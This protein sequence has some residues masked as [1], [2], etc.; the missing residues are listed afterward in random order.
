MAAGAYN[1]LW[2]SFVPPAC[3][4]AHAADPGACLLPCL[5]YGFVQA[6]L[7]IIEAQGDSV[8]LMDHDSV[9][10][11]TNRKS[12]TAPVQRYMA[13]FAANQSACLAAALGPKSS[14]GVFNP[15]CF[16]HTGFKESITIGGTGYIAAFRSW[17]GGASVKLTDKCAE[18]EVLCNPTC[19][20]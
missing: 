11:L 16:I 18:G 2:Q 15:S 14:D 8:V 20:L 5:S 17:L 4:A 6:P 10:K 3:L 1:A 12:V 19:P 9:P 7:F 13:A